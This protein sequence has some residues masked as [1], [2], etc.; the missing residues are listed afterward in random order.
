MQCRKCGNEISG[1]EYRMVAEW[2]FCLQCFERLLS[3]PAEPPPPVVEVEV[4]ASTSV[5]PAQAEPPAEPAASSTEAGPPRCLLC[6]RELAEGQYER[7]ASWVFCPSCYGTLVSMP[8][9]E[10]EP[11]APRPKKSP[12]V[13]PKYAAFKSCKGCGRRIPERAAK[14]IDG[15]P[16]CP[17]CYSAKAR[18]VT[19]VPEIRATINVAGGQGK[20]RSPQKASTGKECESCGRDAAAL[21]TVDGFAI[22]E[23]CL[24][25]DPDLALHLA[26]KRHHLY[27][28][29]LKTELD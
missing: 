29:R 28:E 27:L 24:S 25:T 17:D 3:K 23:A 7:L 20:G 4:R 12:L 1:D 19:V 26:R 14:E 8:D 18:S 6:E 21:R 10:E 15:E 9:D 13:P 22:C 11:A 2:P 16:Y 5:E